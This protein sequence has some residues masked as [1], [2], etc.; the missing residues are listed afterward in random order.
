MSKTALRKYGYIA[1]LCAIIAFVFWLHATGRIS[2]TSMLGSALGVLVLGR[3]IN[4]PLRHFFK[5][6]AAFRQQQWERSEG[7]FIAFLEDLERR[8]WIRYLNYWNYNAY[9]HSLEAMAMNNLG[10][11]ATHKNQLAEA[12]S[13]LQKSLALDPLYPKPYYNLAV[14]AIRQQKMEMA[15]SYFEKSR[16]LGFSN[17]SFDQFMTKVQTAYAE[18]N[19]GLD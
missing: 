2:S 16:E 5:G 4:Y 8:P 19:S 10:A 12:E 15:K 7:L 14:L 3:I 11:I 9:T 17:D 6:L 1:L 13:F 18:V